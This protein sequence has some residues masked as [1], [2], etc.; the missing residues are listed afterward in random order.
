MEMRNSGLDYLMDCLMGK[1]LFPFPGVRFNPTD[2]ELVMFFLMKKLMG[3]KFC[4]VIAE[5]DVYKFAPENLQG[6]LEIF[7]IHSFFLISC[8]FLFY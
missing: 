3:K 7:Y 2:V 5:L 6:T 1:E 4:E 8:T